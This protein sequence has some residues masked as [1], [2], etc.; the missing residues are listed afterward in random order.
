[1]NKKTLILL[2]FLPSLCWGESFYSENEIKETF[3]WVKSSLGIQKE[4]D[5]PKVI[6]SED[7]PYEK[8]NEHCPFCENKRINWFVPKWN[9]IW[10]TKNQDKS[11]L[12]H[13][14]V[15]FFQVKFYLA[16]NDDDGS[17]EEEAIKIQNLYKKHLLKTSI[18]LTSQ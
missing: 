8:Y 6:P 3:F 13:E 17:L 5:I 4:F 10:I 2:L 1:M 11:V 12:V 9:E 14:F 7:V 18:K 15:H 16:E